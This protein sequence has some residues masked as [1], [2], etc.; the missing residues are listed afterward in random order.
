MKI[1]IPW[2]NIIRY[3]K[4]EVIV[5]LISLQSSLIQAIIQ[6]LPL[7]EGKISVRGVISYA[8]QEPWLFTGS[9]QQN[10]LFNSP[11]DKDRYKQVRF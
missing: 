6:E 10:I 9:I 7:I 5:I 3:D 4:A 8:S 2:K 11:M 1:C